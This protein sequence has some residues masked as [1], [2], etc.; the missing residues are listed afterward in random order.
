MKSKGYRSEW[1]RL[2]AYISGKPHM[3]VSNSSI[4][5]N[6]YVSLPSGELKQLKPKT[7]DLKAPLY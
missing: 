4:A 7:Y 6:K 5:T 3:P 1:Q 2:R